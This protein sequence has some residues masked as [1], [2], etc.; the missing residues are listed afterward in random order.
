ML[1]EHHFFNFK[2]S[3]KRFQHQKQELGSLTSSST[4]PHKGTE[5]P[6]EFGIV[7][8]GRKQRCPRHHK[9]GFSTA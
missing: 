5:L 8:N 2:V 7:M 4:T 1:L 9:A 6:K 3:L